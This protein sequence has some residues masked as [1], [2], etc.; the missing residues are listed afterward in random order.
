MLNM[1]SVIIRY[2]KWIANW[3]RVVAAEIRVVFIEF[4]SFARRGS[5]SF[6]VAPAVTCLLESALQKVSPVV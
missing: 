3:D 6:C 4:V 1:A 5:V 2:S